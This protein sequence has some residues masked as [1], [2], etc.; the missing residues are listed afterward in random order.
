MPADDNHGAAWRDFT[1]SSADGLALHGRSYG[2]PLWPHLPVVCLPGLTRTGPRLPRP[3]DVS[4]RHRHRPRR[5]VAFDYRGRG[6][7]DWD[8]DPDHYNPL[9]EMNDVF[10]GMAASASIAQSSSAPRAAAS[11]PC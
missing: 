2:D 3:G 6:R 9:T 10:D 11:S 7:S 5:V 8:R 4:V 1:Y